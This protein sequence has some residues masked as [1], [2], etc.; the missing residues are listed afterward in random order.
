M[1]KNC[2]LL[3]LAAGIGSRYQGK[4][5][6]EPVSKQ[7][8]TLLEFALFDALKTG[9]RKFV[10]I[11]NSEF[12]E[13]YKTKLRTI[14]EKKNAAVIFISQE[15]SSFIPEEYHE[16]LKKR[17]KPLGTAHAV[18]CAKNEIHENFITINADDFY[19]FQSFKTAAGFQRENPDPA[20]FGMI[21][22]ELQN[23]L[24]KNGGVSRGICKTKNQFLQQITEF[25][26][27]EKKDGIIS[28]DSPEGRK[29][30]LGGRDLTSMNFWILKP[31]FFEIAEKELR[32]F[33]EQS[34]LLTDEFYL[35]AVIDSGIRAG[36]IKVK[37]M[38]SSEK[39]FGLTYPEDLN[40]VR[41]EIEKLKQNNGYP[42]HLF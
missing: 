42:L 36:E 16:K 13:I 27:I 19:G 15:P 34:D 6:V 35:P 20:E 5:Q 33:L 37:V 32:N 39:W 8:E 1:N 11:V 38:H 40:P 23:T 14:L 41:Q 18:L 3:I 25:T 30:V 2:S 10:F 22:F 4:K 21:A 12:P 9:I 17:K 26:S 31:R 24:S 7:Q 29:S 28:G